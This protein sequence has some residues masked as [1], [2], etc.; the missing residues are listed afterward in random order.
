MLVCIAFIVFNH[1]IKITHCL[2]EGHLSSPESDT[3]NKRKGRGIGVL[4]DLVFETTKNVFSPSLV[5]L[6]CVCCVFL[7]SRSS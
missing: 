4:W 7:F 6:F 2:Y 5:A 1:S 3:D